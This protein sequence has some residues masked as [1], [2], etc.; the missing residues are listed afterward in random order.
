MGR[1]AYLSSRRLLYSLLRIPHLS[2]STRPS[3]RLRRHCRRRCS[4]ASDNASTSTSTP[5]PPAVKSKAPRQSC[6]PC[7]QSPGLVRSG[8][9]SGIASAL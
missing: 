9:N 4:Q 6:A 3:V 5:P 7:N 1:S 2:T 8:F